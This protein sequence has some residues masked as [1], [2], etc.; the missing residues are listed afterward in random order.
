MRAGFARAGTYGGVPLGVLGVYGPL[1]IY[2]MYSGRQGAVRRVSE[3]R[4]E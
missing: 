3:R 4:V 2:G 1:L